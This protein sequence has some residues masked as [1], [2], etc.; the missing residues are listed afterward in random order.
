MFSI[1][2]IFQ[3]CANS[4]QEDV[5]NTCSQRVNSSYSESP[6]LGVFQSLVIRAMWQLVDA[7]VWAVGEMLPT[8]DLHH[9]S[10]VAGRD[11]KHPLSVL[12]DFS[13]QTIGTRDSSVLRVKAAQSGTSVEF[14]HHLL[15]EQ[16][17]SLI[18][19]AA[20]L[21]CSSAIMEYLQITRKSQ[22]APLSD[23][24]TSS[25]RKCPEIPP[26]A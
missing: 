23:G 19:G 4:R 22:A 3:G 17:G 8:E 1:V 2:G 14:T 11:P 24:P 10:A 18:N 25:H 12:D 9:S 21:G 6:H 20:F 16:H 5:S 13:I 26:P 7:N 15:K